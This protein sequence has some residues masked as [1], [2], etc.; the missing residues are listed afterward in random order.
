MLSLISPH[1]W[2]F[3][4]LDFLL[5]D[6]FSLFFNPPMT[7]I[8]T[9]EDFRLFVYTV[10]GD[11]KDGKYW[12]LGR[13]IFGSFM[14]FDYCGH[15]TPEKFEMI[16]GKRIKFDMSCSSAEE[17][18]GLRDQMIRTSH[19]FMILY[20]VTLRKTFENLNELRQNIYSLREKKMEDFIPIVL[21]ATMCDLEDRREVSKSEGEDLAKSWGCPFFETS[22][23]TGENVDEA[24]HAAYQEYL[25]APKEVVPTAEDSK[26]KCV[27]M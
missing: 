11:F 13:F 14:E 16:D 26:G 20:N 2:I 21:V 22:A 5:I 23:E 19:A 10:P 12:L 8:P 15:D 9:A 27:V 3:L 7:G 1:K 17:Y 18:S 4:L 6:A 25:K 24:F